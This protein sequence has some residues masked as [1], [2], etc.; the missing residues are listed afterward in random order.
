VQPLMS[1]RRRQHHH[2]QPTMTDLRSLGHI[3]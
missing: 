2:V 1:L 3:I